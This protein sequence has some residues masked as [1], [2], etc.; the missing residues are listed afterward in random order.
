MTYL[1]GVDYFV[2]YDVFPMAIRGLVTP[3]DDG[4]FSIYLNRRYPSSVLRKTFRH[5]VD[6]VQNDDFYNEIP[7]DQV[8]N[9]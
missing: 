2:Y 3:N 1:P 6:H 7:V 4:T 9:L 5:E 8:E